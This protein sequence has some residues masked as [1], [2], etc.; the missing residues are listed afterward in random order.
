M[1][2]CSIA[3][4]IYQFR[5]KDGVVSNNLW[6]N[7][8]LLVQNPR[9]TINQELCFMLDTGTVTVHVPEHNLDFF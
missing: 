8:D 6:I 5:A 2:I 3:L 9:D 1:Q 7:I 4:D